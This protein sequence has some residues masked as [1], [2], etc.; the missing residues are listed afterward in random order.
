MK[1]KLVCDECG[2][3][4]DV[5]TS[6][7]WW[8]AWGRNTFDLA[9]QKNKGKLFLCEKCEEENWTVCCDCQALIENDHYGLGYLLGEEIYG[10]SLCPECA[11][12]RGLKRTCRIA[13]Y[14]K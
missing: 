8:T 3:T 5:I 9:W 1:K 14:T 11:E 13:N 4:N 6:T 2:E 12:K 7:V 10:D